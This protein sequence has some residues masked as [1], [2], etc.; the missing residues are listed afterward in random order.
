VKQELIQ[1]I[2]DRGEF[3]AMEDGYIC[4]WPHM[5]PVR[6]AD[7]GMTGGGGAMSAPE[8][9]VI[10]DELDRRN[11]DWDEQVRSDLERLAKEQP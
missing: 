1:I 9:R 4:W 10:A 2:Q 5:G 11:K 3:V 8:L 6:H 7:G